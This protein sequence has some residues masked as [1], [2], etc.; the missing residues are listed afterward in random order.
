MM[1]VRFR[2]LRMAFMA[3]ISESRGGNNRHRFS[4]TRPHSPSIICAG[5]LV[6][7]AGSSAFR[8]TLPLVEFPF[9]SLI[10]QD[11]WTWQP[12]LYMVFKQQ[13]WDGFFV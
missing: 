10:W 11:T 3:A 13:H 5:V 9:E 4:N 6:G 7:L 12:L 2:N 8:F 1:A